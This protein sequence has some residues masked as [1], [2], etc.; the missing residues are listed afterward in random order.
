MVGVRYI[1]GAYFT[2]AVVWAWVLGEGIKAKVG[3]SR[4][5]LNVKVPTEER[6]SEV[7]KP[8]V[9]IVTWHVWLGGQCGVIDQS[10]M[11]DE[12]C[13]APRF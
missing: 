11:T 10:V 8:R 4:H 3:G 7:F 6:Y 1:E 2:L 5:M 9:L 13:P 12:A